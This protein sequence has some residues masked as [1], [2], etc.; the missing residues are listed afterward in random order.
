MAIDHARLA[1][2]LTVAQQSSS[3]NEALTAFR[4]AVKMLTAENLNFN[5]YIAGLQ[6]QVNPYSQYS[7]QTSQYQAYQQAQQNA[8]SKAWRE[9]QEEARNTR[10]PREHLSM[11]GELLDGDLKL[12]DKTR[13]FLDSL[14][15]GHRQY[16]HLTE[17]QAAVLE[18]IYGEKFPEEA[19]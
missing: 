4:M 6:K 10:T 8:Q 7:A 11:L 13:S 5:E 1:R 16:G 19:A 12:S 3:D 9:A 17:K 15:A 18:R 14:R 2:F